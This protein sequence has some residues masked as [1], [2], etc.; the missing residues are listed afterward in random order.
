MAL[1]MQKSIELN[2]M[3]SKAFAD[4]EGE[5]LI[6]VWEFQEQVRQLRESANKA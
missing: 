5:E 1:T 3:G 4:L 6:E 2:W